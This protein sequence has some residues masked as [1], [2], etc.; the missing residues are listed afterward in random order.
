MDIDLKQLIL[1]DGQQIYYIDKLCAEYIY[2]EIFVEKVYHSHGIEI[3]DGATIF[4]I[5][6]NIGL[7]SMYAN[8]VATNLNIYTFEPVPQIFEVLQ[9]NILNSTNKIHTYNI[10]LGEKEE[11]LEIIFYPKVSGDS[12]IVPWELNSKTQRYVDHYNEMFKEDM[13]IALL[14]PKFLRKQVVRYFLKKLYKGQ[15]VPCKIRTFSSIIKENQ[16]NNVD[17]VKIDAENYEWPVLMGIQDKDWTKIQQLAIEVHTHIPG[18]EDLDQR[19]KNLLE[20]KGFTCEFGE[21][22]RETLQG[23]FM[24]YARK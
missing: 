8:R 18:G 21:P 14:V 20:S 5:G 3:K 15:K 2:R 7:F 16:I 19:I 13:K 24:L 10:G 1:P 12:T 6:G 11:N 17:L 22:S 9:A 23:V 4:D